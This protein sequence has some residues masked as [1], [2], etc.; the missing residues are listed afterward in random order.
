LF[1]ARAGWSSYAINL[2]GHYPSDYEASLAQVTFED[3]LDDVKMVMTAL[4]IENCA[5][6]GHSLGGLIAQRT[7]E[8][9]QS[10]AALVA[11]ASAPP[12]GVAL[13]MNNDLPYSEAIINSMWGLINMQPVKFSYGVAE[14]TVLNNIEETQRENIF[15]MFVA[16][17]F[18][19]SYQVAQGVCVDAGQ[20]KCPKLVIGCQRDLMAPESMERKLAG[21]LKA[22]Y[23]SYA[24]FAHL[25]MLEKGWEHSAGDIGRWLMDKV[26]K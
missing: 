23:I 16:E 25:P 1:F 17:S 14:K 18:M 6:I 2:R 24:Q 19:V 4:S 15:P 7:A 20:I 5:L 12:A 9:F 13:E 21:F 26:Q 11:V 3:Y 8:N 10:V 22:D